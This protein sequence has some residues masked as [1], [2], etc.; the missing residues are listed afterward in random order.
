MAVIIDRQ[1][2][3]ALWEP[4][5]KQRFPEG[6]DDPHPC[7]L[8]V[9]TEEAYFWNSSTGKVGQ[10]L[11]QLRSIAR[12]DKFWAN[13]KGKLQLDTKPQEM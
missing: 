6:L 7:L 8:K 2:M 3:E 1:K 11:F 12:G 10:L 4:E 13:K 9:I 5:L